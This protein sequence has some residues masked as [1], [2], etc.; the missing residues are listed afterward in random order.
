MLPEQCQFC[1]ELYCVPKDQAPLLPCSKCGQ[2]PHKE[3]LIKA[4]KLNADVEY[5]SQDIAIIVNPTALKN[6]NYLCVTC[7]EQYI[8]DPDAGKKVCTA[9]KTT[10][11]S[12]N[13]NIVNNVDEI[14]ELSNTDNNTN[15]VV[16]TN[17]DDKVI[18]DD[19]HIICSFYKKGTC[20]YGV[21]GK[22]CKFFHP[23]LC[24]KFLRFGKKHSRGCNTI[25]CKKFHP[26]VCPKSLNNQQCDKNHCTFFYHVRSAGRNA[27]HDK[28]GQHVKKGGRQTASSNDKNFLDIL[29]SFKTEILKEFNLKVAMILSQTQEK[30]LAP[31]VLKPP[32]AVLHGGY[33]QIPPPPV[34]QVGNQYAPSSQGGNLFPQPPLNII[35]GISAPME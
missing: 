5:T 19:D 17:T 21:S 35:C 13:N 2:E 14:H 4:L 29:R 9:A 31:P 26:T 10:E 16:Q 11:S 32:A 8:P 33:Q 6:V 12:N 15:A 24:K 3:C 23:K 22:G 18:G 30:D 1:S 34:F 27:V 28:Q 25:D 20:K 7:Q